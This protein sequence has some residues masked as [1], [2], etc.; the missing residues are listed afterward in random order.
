M[1]SIHL[2]SYTVFWRNYF[3]R[4]RLNT[5]KFFCALS[6]RLNTTINLVRNGY[7][8]IQIEEKTMVCIP[9]TR[10]GLQAKNSV[11][12]FLFGHMMVSCSLVNSSKNSSKESDVKECEV[13]ENKAPFRSQA[14]RFIRSEVVPFLGLA[15]KMIYD[16][17]DETLEGY[18]EISK[19]SVCNVMILEKTKLATES[20]TILEKELSKATLVVWSKKQCDEETISDGDIKNLSSFSEAPSLEDDPLESIEGPNTY[21]EGIDFVKAF[22]IAAESSGKLKKGTMNWGGQGYIFTECQD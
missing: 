17:K 5:R 14:G 19:E 22:E 2:F 18:F 7:C 3:H 6:L 1:S 10:A 11:I 4:I 13:V 8:D 12:L 15:S 20:V 9:T 21:V 16:S